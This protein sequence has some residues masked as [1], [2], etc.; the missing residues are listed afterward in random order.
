MSPK[1]PSSKTLCIADTCSLIYL[2]D[3]ELMRKPLFLW[4]FDE[5]D[6]VYSDFVWRN[7]LKPQLRRLPGKI[8]KK[9]DQRRGE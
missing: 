9:T 4:L 6:V 3:I 7:E 5:F 8:R 1:T 2:S